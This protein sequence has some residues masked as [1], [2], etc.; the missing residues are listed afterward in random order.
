VVQ[1][2]EDH[3]E[4]ERGFAVVLGDPGVGGRFEVGE[5]VDVVDF[6]VVADFEAP[7]FAEGDAYQVGVHPRCLLARESLGGQRP[8]RGCTPTV[9]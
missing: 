6:E 7:A 1:P 5:A 3:L 2:Q 8:G 4:P 9:T